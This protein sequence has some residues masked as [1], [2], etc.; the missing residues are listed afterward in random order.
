VVKV[1][2]TPT[3]YRRVQSKMFAVAFK[4]RVKRAGSAV[5]TEIMR[6]G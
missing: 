6:L 2:S 3:L 1:A 4:R 5:L